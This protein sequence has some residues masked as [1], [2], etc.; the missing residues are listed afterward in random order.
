MFSDQNLTFSIPISQPGFFTASTTDDPNSSTINSFFMPRN[1]Y[2][3]VLF[4]I[5]HFLSVFLF[6]SF[7]SKFSL[8]IAL[9]GQWSCFIM[10]YWPLSFTHILK[11]FFPILDF[12]FYLSAQSIFC[13][14]L[15]IY[16]WI[17]LFISSVSSF[18]ILILMYLL[19]WLGILRSSSIDTILN[20]PDA[21]LD[22]LLDEE[23]FLY[24]LKNGNPKLLDL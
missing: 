17:L 4:K 11:T 23:D 5:F 3:F 19:E 24:D 10:S 22:E 18:L 6:F 16:C 12:E 21:K 1:Y 7:I 14:V 20:R 2:F 13:F 9:L 8:M 15:L